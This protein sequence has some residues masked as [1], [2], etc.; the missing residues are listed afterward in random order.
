MRLAW[1]LT[2]DLHDAEDIVQM[3]LLKINQRF[4]SLKSPAACLR[5][6]THAEHSTT[7]VVVGGLYPAPTAPT[8]LQIS[9]RIDGSNDFPD[10]PVG[11]TQISTAVLASGTVIRIVSDDPD[12]LDDINPALDDIIAAAD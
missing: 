2:N 5:S 4:E 9:D 7:L 1:F 12:H 8:H 10:I 6:S 11:P 3:A